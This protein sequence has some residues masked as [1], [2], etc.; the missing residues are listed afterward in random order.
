MTPRPL[1]RGDSRAR[2]LRDAA[3]E[4]AGLDLRV[5]Y[6]AL[7]DL[8]SLG[9]GSQI[10]GGPLGGNRWL[11]AVPTAHATWIMAPYWSFTGLGGFGLRWGES[12]EG[13]FRRERTWL[14][15]AKI[16]FLP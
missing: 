10:S 4:E 11:S 16:A 7:A 1:G 12:A 2:R 9:L 5:S 8:L 13:L 15:G 14:L 3:T 6:E